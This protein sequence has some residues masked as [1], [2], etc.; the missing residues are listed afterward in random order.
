MAGEFDD[1]IPGDDF[2]DLIP[3]R[4]DRAKAAIVSGAETAV[5][6]QDLA[7]QAAL[8][9][10]AN[11]IG[12]PGS[13]EALVR[14]GATAG[15][16]AATGLPPAYEVKNLLPTPEDVAGFMG[17]LGFQM[18]R[19][20]ESA[21]GKI[22][23]GAVEGMAS[24]PFGA[25]GVIMGALGGGGAEAAGQALEGTPYEQAG[26]VV[27]GVGLPLLAGQV[28]AFPATSSSIARDALEGLAPSQVEMTQRLMEAARAKGVDLTVAEAIAQVTGRTPLQDVQRVVEQ[29]RGGG[30]RMQDFMNRRPG[31]VEGAVTRE[32]DA[33][34]P[35]SPIPAEIPPRVQAAAQDV[36]KDVGEARTQAV[37]P[38]YNAADPVRVPAQDVEGIIAKIDDMIAADKTGILSGG[39]LAELRR[40]LI[41]AP[42]KDAVPGTRAQYVD[43]KFVPS[44]PGTPAQARVPVT[45]IENLDRA[46][47]FFRDR[48]DK[49]DIAADAID[50][51]TA[52]KIGPLLGELRDLMA[53]SSDDYRQGLAE[54]ERITNEIANPAIR[55][56]VGQLAATDPLDAGAFA[57]Q[58]Q[59]LFPAKPETLNPN[60][61][62]RAVL[63]VNEKDPTAA[64]DLTR[65]FLQNAFNEASK[66]QLTNAENAGAR[67]RILVAGNPQQERNLSAALEALD[68]RN[69]TSIR[70]GFENL[71]QVLEATGRRLAP[72]SQTEF[73]RL[74]TR[75]MEQG[76]VQQALTP[77]KTITEWVQRARYRKN[78][79]ELA[80]ILTAPDAIDRLKRLSVLA[81]NSDQAISMVASM[82]ALP[83]PGQTGE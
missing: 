43:G 64:R 3:S 77:K 56:P 22:A 35:A 81:P 19:R 79:E 42:A 28:R 53:R 12:L 14:S 21:P 51:E 60:A 54:Y 36:I 2:A 41:E 44:T 80:D 58:R 47:K 23:A 16:E 6:A 1:L 40:R 82:M 72:G 62:R 76:G 27:A 61:V 78:A 55:S 65:Q 49:P 38:L 29:S 8:R 15:M 10:I 17:K 30:V 66:K 37:R 59:I 34:G 67:F 69:G 71:L 5:N 46:R 31:Q 4:G 75:E 73:N 33:I 70:Q 24:S 32:L 48:M 11:L 68:P 9:G 20:P 45:D 50:K 18:N 83:K 63:E 26:R 25:G 57:K 52:A 13:V 74:L 7:S 39:P